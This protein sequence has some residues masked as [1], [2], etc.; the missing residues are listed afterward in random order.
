M[1]DSNTP[2]TQ[3]I[4]QSHELHM[5]RLESRRI[6]NQLYFLQEALA[7]LGGKNASGPQLHPIA[8]R[9][10]C[11]QL[12]ELENKVLNVSYRAC[13]LLGIPEDTVEEEFA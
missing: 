13:N 5:I 12:E 10:L 3:P 6:S 8:I 2:V 1:L 9:G 7:R 11:Q 4:N